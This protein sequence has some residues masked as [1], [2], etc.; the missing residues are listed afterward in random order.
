MFFDAP[1]NAIDLLCQKGTFLVHDH[2]VG[3]QDSPVLFH[4]AAFHQASHSPVLVQKVIPPQ[5]QDSMLALVELQKV[6]LQT[7][8]VRLDGSTVSWC[9]SHPSL[10]GALLRVHSVHHSSFSECFIC[11]FLLNC[12]YATLFFLRNI[13]CHN[14]FSPKLFSEKDGSFTLH[15]LLHVAST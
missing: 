2:S 8:Q 11:I 4:R 12:C 7:V 3:H 5:G 1:Q 9:V 10:F 14:D 15:P 13:L 6:T